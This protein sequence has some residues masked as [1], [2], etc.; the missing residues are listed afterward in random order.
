MLRRPHVLKILLRN[1][2]HGAVVALGG[3]VAELPCDA[4]GDS[5]EDLDHAID[6]PGVRSDR[7][8]CQDTAKPAT[9][10]SGM[11]WEV[12]TV[13][14][15]PRILVGGIKNYGDAEGLASYARSLPTDGYGAT[16]RRARRP[17]NL[18]PED[19]RR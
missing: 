14:R 18:R 9:R 16:V 1:G 12:W 8:D 19:R 5:L 3:I 17:F 6:G 4:P 15:T 11:I 7:H 10:Q 2:T 13:E